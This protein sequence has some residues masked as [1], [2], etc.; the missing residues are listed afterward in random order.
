MHA[1][2][3]LFQGYRGIG[4]IHVLFQGYRNFEEY[5]TCIIIHTLRI[6][7]CFC[8]SFL[9]VYGLHFSKEDHVHL[10]HLL[11]EL[12]TGDNLESPL[13]GTWSTLLTHLLK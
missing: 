4:I 5:Y 11:F 13:L 7:I 3:V 2:C 6:I 9:R 10:I 12:V 1:V 8:L